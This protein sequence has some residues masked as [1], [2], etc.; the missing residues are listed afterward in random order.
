MPPLTSLI[1]AFAGPSTPAF[2][3]PASPP[4]VVVLYADDLGYGDLSILN[5]ESKIPT[6]HLDQLAKEG[7]TL[8]DGHSSSG[9]CSPSRY[10]LLTGRY[11]WRDFHGIV[12]VYGPSKF[13]AERLTLPEMLQGKGY[14]TACIGKWHLGWDWGAL[15][16]KDV[17]PRT[18][19][20][21]P[22]LGPEAF[23]WSQPIPDG[24]LAHGFDHYFGD[25]VINFP[26]YT[27][28]EDDR[29]V[30]APDALM[31]SKTWK[32]LRE[33]NWECRP[34]AM[35][36]GWDPYA[37][38]S[39]LTE[40][41]VAYVEG[42]AEQAQPFFLYVP[43]PSP[44]APILPSEEFTAVSKAGAY[45]DYVAQ[46]DAACGAI[47]AA[48]GSAGLAS[49]TLVIFSSDNGPE[50]YAYARDK[51]L[52]HWSSEPFRGLKRDIYEGGHHVPFLVRWP[53]RIEPG[54]E[55]HAL[56]SQVD[57]MATL[58]SIVGAELPAD[59]AEDSH[60]LLPLWLGQTEAV[61]SSHVHN[62]YANKYAFRQG[63]WLLVDAKNGYTSKRN[64]GWEERRGIEPDGDELAELY[65]LG[66]DPGQRQDLAAGKPERVAAMRA[67]LQRL[68][69]AGF[70]AP[71]LAKRER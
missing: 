14:A 66:E 31:D 30:E 59:A 25:S 21:R 5:S 46:T 10:A 18:V 42:R 51:D 65:H 9:I 60:D 67:E 20:G 32:P 57:L 47:L 55:T 52:E 53:G 49:N 37:N 36:T 38:L 24:P 61:R 40:R 19:D 50:H 63:P 39:T 34:G 1:L 43:F 8:R 56:V 68:R 41:A 64:P 62:T 13:E 16:R 29:V 33:G 2:Q 71:R 27:W 44:H 70:S 22:V 12:G 6:P 28:I 35:V 45:G 54:S 15:R 69:D 11:H 48:L 4:N 58:A 26:P 7:L 17:G 3:E 23:D